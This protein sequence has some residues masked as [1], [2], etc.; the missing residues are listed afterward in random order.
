VLALHS[1]AAGWTIE[2]T[3]SR[4]PFD[5]LLIATSLDS[6]RRLLASLPV[7][8]AQRAAAMLPAEAASG[9]VVA[10]GYRAQS[11]PLPAIPQGFGFLVEASPAG[12]HDLLACTFLHQKFPRR[13]PAGATLLRAFF[14]SSA[15][16]SL[17]RHFDQEI[18]E[19]ARRQL[20]GILGPLP[21]HADITIVRRWPRSLPQYEVGHLARIAEFETC[22]SA[23]C[24]IQVAGNALRGVGLPDLI[25]HATQAAHALAR[26]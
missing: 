23:L 19:I 8:E 5:R 2:T 15:A 26:A 11:H 4:E 24:G 17:S 3:S 10:L 21:E 25:R 22:V 18:A 13:A 20:M 16:D 12:D 1:V 6:T 14:A 9:L 7:S